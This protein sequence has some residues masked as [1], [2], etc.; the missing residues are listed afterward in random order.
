MDVEKI[1]ELKKFV[2]TCEEDPSILLKPEFSFFKDFIESFGGKVKK[3]KMGYEKMKSEDSTEEKTEEEEEEEEEEEDEEEEE[4]EE[5]EEQDDPEELELIKEETEECPPLAPIIEGEL[6]EE[7]IEEICKLKEEAVN[8]VGDKKYEEALEKYN[9]IISFGNPSAMIYT[10]RASILLNL[11]RPKACIRDCTEALNLNIDSANAYKI[12]AK[13]YRYLGKWE[14]AHA[15]MEQGQKIDYD[16]NLWDMQKLIQ[17]KYKKIY[18]RRR[19][20]INKEEEKQRLKREKELKKRLA[21]KKKAEKMYKE[22]TKRK[23]YD[24]DSSDSSYSEPDFSGDFPGGMPGGMPGMPGMPGGMGGMGG[25]PGMP[26]GFPGMP[27]GMGGMPGGMGGMPGGMG[28]MPGGMPGMPDLNSPEMK[29]LFNNPQFF[30][31][32]QNM[33]SNPDLINKYANDPKYKNIFENL[34][35]SDLGGMMGGKPKP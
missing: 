25:M 35:N 22:N 7:Q 34:K 6:S 17:E 33:M 28:G 24:S 14:F 29:E 31:M 5:E 12:R 9:K 27:G 23:N 13:A 18:E 11:K 2:A 30:Q 19:Y 20:K 3:D 16:E 10:K 32:M 15:D 1:E 8:L 26:G 21:A 4:E